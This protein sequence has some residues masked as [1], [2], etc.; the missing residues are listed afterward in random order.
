MGINGQQKRDLRVPILIS[1]VD[2]RLIKHNMQALH[3]KKINNGLLYP[4]FALGCRREVLRKEIS[5]LFKSSR[6]NLEWFKNNYDYLTK[7]YD[8]RWVII[9]QKKVVE[10]SSNFDEVLSA[11]KKY[12]PSS[13]IVEFI[14]SEPIAMFF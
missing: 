1:D 5:D 9:T 6:E 13:I 4:M 10:S 14:E 2:L 3:R 7:N 11:A 12:D 8:K